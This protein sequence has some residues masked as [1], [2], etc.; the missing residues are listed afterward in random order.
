MISL[1]SH[2][3]A[4]HVF[5]NQFQLYDNIAEKGGADGLN[6]WLSAPA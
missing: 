2:L 1:G 4:Q 6:A 3:I 5:L